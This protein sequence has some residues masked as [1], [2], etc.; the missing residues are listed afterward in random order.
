MARLAALFL[1]FAASQASALTPRE[2][3]LA[4]AKGKALAD[5]ISNFPDPKNGTKKAALLTPRA[6]AG[7]GQGQ[8]FGGRDFEL[9]GPQERDEE[10]G[11]LDAA[12]GSWR[13][14]RARL[15]RT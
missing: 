8:G 10:G 12:S 11:P 9:P 13:R 15:W 4:E 7:G 3:Q 2:R 6:A 5:V 1:A 14:P